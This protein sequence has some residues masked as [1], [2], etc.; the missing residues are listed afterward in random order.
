VTVATCPA[1]RKAVGGGGFVVFDTGVS[2]V[3]NRVAIH[4]SV[5]FTFATADDSWDVQAVETAPDNFTTWHLIAY[6]VCVS[7][8][9]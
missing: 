2:G 6:A 7:V 8:S 1:G 3:V 5:P 4:A 9:S